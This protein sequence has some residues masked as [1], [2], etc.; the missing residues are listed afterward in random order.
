MGKAQ[1][2]FWGADD[3]KLIKHRSFLLLSCDSH[4][5][6]LQLQILEIQLELLQKLI[7]RNRPAKRGNMCMKSLLDRFSE[8]KKSYYQIDCNA[9]K[10]FTYNFEESQSECLEFLNRH[11]E[12]GEKKALF[13]RDLT[14]QYNRHGKHTHSASL[15]LLG[16]TL[17]PIF[18]TNIDNRLKSFVPNYTSWCE[19][20]YDFQY[21][22]FL[23][24]M[25]HDFASCIELGT[26]R[27]NDSEQH[28]SL[29]FHLGNHNIQYS[30]YKPFP[31]KVDN[32]PFRF[33]PELIENYFYYRA[34]RG[35]CEHGI[36]AG[37]LFF[38]GFVKNF[39]KN[40]NGRFNSCGSM[41]CYGLGWNIGHLAFAAYAADAI[42]C[43]NI[44]LGGKT[45]KEEYTQYG[46]TPLVY[47]EHPESK[48][49]VEAFPLQFM[50]CLLDTI[51][52]I[53][54]FE[55]TLS[56]REILQGIKLDYITNNEIVI[57][58]AAIIAQQKGFKRW[59]STVYKGLHRVGI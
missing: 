39:L 59:K 22:W 12:K 36:L 49:S 8:Q 38:D 44:W 2:V 58:W 20:E 37:Y 6:L 54:R 51:E 55:D 9:E 4:Y 17:L 43:H 45:E 19:D 24:A 35:N 23:P 25:Y 33:S 34:C 56:P 14:P 46:L 53:K 27:T 1:L 50:L 15:Y 41:N 11:Y 48:L 31:Y 30:P 26:I 28:R 29:R 40:T 21:I 52:P 3:K 42:I 7:L 5:N 57:S 10:L 18:K 32:I 16:T 13:N 47:T